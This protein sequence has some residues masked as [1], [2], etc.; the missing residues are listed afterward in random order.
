MRDFLILGPNPYSE[1]LARILEYSKYS[2]IE[3]FGVFIALSQVSFWFLFFFEVISHSCTG[4]T[5]I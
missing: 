3:R 1:I 2:L 4:T 5:T